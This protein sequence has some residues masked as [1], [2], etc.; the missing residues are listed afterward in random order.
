MSGRQTVQRS[1]AR[2]DS[3][4]RREAAVAIGFFAAMCVAVLVKAPQLLEPDDYAYRASIVA[5]SQGHL[6]LT[7]AQYLALRAQLSANDGGGIY[8]W[9][10]LAS[11]KW[12]SQ[13]N[14]GYPFFAVV[15]QWLHA[16]RAAPLI[17]GALACGGLFYGA[18]RW[19]GRWG[20]T[21]AVAAYCSSGAALNFAWRPTM[22][23]FTDASLIAG[24]AGL[25]LGVLLATTDPPA[26]RL[27]LGVI[28]FVA[29]EGAVLIRYTDV[30][31]LIVAI[32]AVLVLLRVSGLTRAMLL[33]WLATVLLFA[34]GD[35]ALNR[36]LYGG[37]L[38]TGY[39][40]GL[41]T[42]STSAIAPNVERMPARL[43]ESLPM[44]LLAAGALLWIVV[45]LVRSG[46][47][48]A[49]S[50][51]RARA[52][53]DA[54]VALV[55]FAGWIG[56]W[57]LYATYAWTVGQTIGVTNPEHVVRFYV[58]V[59]GLIALLAAWLL[60]QLP[61]WLPAAALALL[62][63]TALWSYQTPANRIIAGPASPRVMTIHDRSDATKDSYRRG[64]SVPS[65]PRTRPVGR[66][67]SSTP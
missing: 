29:L 47:P 27:T 11:G 12:I 10:H 20:G 43:V 54:T 35:V 34:L 38:T 1:L 16:L 63:G 66:A 58:P 6:L 17:Y 51:E 31:V 7:N 55:L 36:Y 67:G 15:F 50:P 60:A 5:L 9:V 25:L 56:V 48:D 64:V 30:V 40:S 37:F 61:R 45:R 59:L 62:V 49:S 52:R 19:L 22:P 53:T 3:S 44:S 39:R 57:G 42:F 41:V 4:F 65:S 32:V 8:Q 23:T 18:R 13:K 28:A 26:R 14:P 46:R 33:S 21:F 24:A 2:G